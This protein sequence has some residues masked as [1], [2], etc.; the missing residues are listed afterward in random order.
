VN[1]SNASA[2]LRRTS[3]GLALALAGL[4]AITGGAIAQE[5]DLSFLGRYTLEPDC[6]GEQVRLQDDRF[7]VADL[8]CAVADVDSESNGT[9]EL[10]LSDC[11][12]GGAPTK[13]NSVFGYA[14]GGDAVALSFWGPI[15]PVFRCGG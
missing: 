14:V 4:M 13:G 8:V 2:R 12:Q 6:A 9:F 7:V 10:S 3:T 15:I 5:R 1:G 11:T